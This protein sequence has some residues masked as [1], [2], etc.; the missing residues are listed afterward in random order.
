MLTVRIYQ[1]FSHPPNDYVRVSIRRFETPDPLSTKRVNVK[2]LTQSLFGTGH[3]VSSS[4]EAILRSACLRVFNVQRFSPLYAST[5][6]PTVLS[7]L[8][9]GRS[10]DSMF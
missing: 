5:P 6:I 7:G 2:L 10:S 4:I 1:S 3:L 9:L 8:S